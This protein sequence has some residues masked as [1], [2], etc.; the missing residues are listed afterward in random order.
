MFGEQNIVPDLS[1]NIHG[2]ALGAT[3]RS[4]I[5]PDQ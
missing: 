5:N 4:F 3:L 2:D 1:C